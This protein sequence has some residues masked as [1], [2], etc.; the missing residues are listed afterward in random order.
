MDGHNCSLLLIQIAISTYK[1]NR[2]RRLKKNKLYRQKRT[3]RYNYVKYSMMI[4]VDS[5][6]SL[7]LMVKNTSEKYKMWME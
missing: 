4:M 2:Q 6:K 1:P 5:S 3:M 7:N